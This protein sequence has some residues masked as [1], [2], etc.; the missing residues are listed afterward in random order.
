MKLSE[1]HQAVFMQRTDQLYQRQWR[2]A[3]AAGQTLDYPLGDL[4]H[5]VNHNLGRHHCHYCCGPVE[6]GT[7]EIDAKIPPERGGSFNFHNLAIV[8]KDCG[9]AKGWLDHFEYRELMSLLRTW[10]PRVRR[11][12]IAKLQ[13]GRGVSLEAREKSEW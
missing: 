10:S 2:Q 4:R 8:C 12:F 13:A 3:R 7:F 5:F 11:R 9:Q 1:H 6:P